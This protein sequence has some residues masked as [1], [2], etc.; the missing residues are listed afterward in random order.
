MIKEFSAFLSAFRAGRELAN[1]AAWKRAGNASAAL[2][3]LLGAAVTIAGGF[4]YGI[5]L[6]PGQIEQIAGG[7]VALVSLVHVVL[8]TVT[9][10]KVGLPAKPAPADPYP[11]IGS[12]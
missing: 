8:T 9:S 4:G 2:V 11:R 3:A 12:D 1:A 5:T 7:V 6:E 10:K